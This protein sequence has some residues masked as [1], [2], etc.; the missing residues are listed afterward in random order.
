MENDGTNPWGPS[1]IESPFGAF[2]GNEGADPQTAVDPW[3]SWTTSTQ[4]RPLQ[5]ARVAFQGTQI[6]G[7]KRMRTSSGGAGS[8]GEQDS[9]PARARK[10]TRMLKLEN[11]AVPEEKRGGRDKRENLEKNILRDLGERFTYTEFRYRVSEEAR[12]F[13][14]QQ[15]SGFQQRMSLLESF[16]E[17]RTTNTPRFKKGEITIVD[18]TDPFI[19]AA[20]ACS[21]FEIVTRIFVRADV[22]GGKVLLV[23]EAHKYLTRERGSQVLTKTLLSIVRQQRHLGMRLII[24]TQEP[25]VIPE[26]LL[27]LCTITIMH[28]F[29]SISWFT[30]LSQHVSSQ[31]NEAAFDTVVKLETGQAIVLAPA[32]LGVF[33]KRRSDV[34]GVGEQEVAAFGRRYLITKTRKRVTADGGASILAT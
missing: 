17:P 34:Y 30:H 12:T 22:E 15:K 11:S 24:S 6:F 3:A 1:E 27:D 10:T 14:P 5:I 29:S 31:F 19:D 28:R 26:V 16:L 33:P 32:G 8:D 13:N 20:S 7:T 23:D 25:T 9:S 4:H 2:Y 21:L 18:L